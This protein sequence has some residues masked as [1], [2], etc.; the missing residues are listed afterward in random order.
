MFV[1]DDMGDQRICR[2]FGIER[3]GARRPEDD[4]WPSRK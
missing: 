4:R 1:P 2:F 3:Y